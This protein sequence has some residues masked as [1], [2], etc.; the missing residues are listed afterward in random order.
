MIKERTSNE[1]N[2]LMVWLLRSA[3]KFW[4]DIAVS[5]RALTRLSHDRSAPSGVSMPASFIRRH[6]GLPPP[7]LGQL[8][9]NHLRRT[10]RNRPQ[11]LVV[12][13]TSRRH[14]ALTFDKAGKERLVSR[15]LGDLKTGQETN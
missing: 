7:K 10:R 1:L 15:G 2:Q 12:V 3:R 6:T 13:T 14:R 4:N 8:Q 5:L 11:P 9:V